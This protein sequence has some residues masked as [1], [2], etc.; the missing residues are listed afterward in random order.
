M[1]RLG[2]ARANIRPLASI[3]CRLQ[4]LAGTKTT[5]TFLRLGRIS[6]GAAI[7]GT[8]G[9]PVTAQEDAA[10][11]SASS[12]ELQVSYQKYKATLQK[13][14][15][16][17]RYHVRLVAGR[18]YIVVLDGLGRGADLKLELTSPISPIRLEGFTGGES[19][20]AELQVTETGRY[21]IVVTSEPGGAVPTP[22][23]IE[24]APDCSNFAPTTCTLAI[25]KSRQSRFASGAD[26]D[27]FRVSLT[28]GH[29]YTFKLDLDVPAELGIFTSSDS[30]T[31]EGQLNAATAKPY[32]LILQ[33]FKPTE[34]GTYFVRVR[35]STEKT[36]TYRLAATE[37]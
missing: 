13:R 32:D 5:R 9:V 30:L 17:D 14:N 28:A 35:P 20:S 27:R 11:Q 2:A 33:E 37:P 24:V 3:P 15:E 23:R 31:A 16:K 26:G 22:Y 29:V 8:A 18:G 36:D 6:L 19:V 1:A 7:L 12:V 21:N 34:T 10:S 4:V 25:G